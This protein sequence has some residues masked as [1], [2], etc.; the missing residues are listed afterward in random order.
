MHTYLLSW[1]CYGLESCVNISD[2]E[3]N[4]VWKTLKGESTARD[5]SLNQIVSMITLRARFNS[6]RHYEIYLIDTDD[7]ITENDLRNMF[8]QDPQGS[9]DLIRHRGRMLYSDRNEDHKIVIR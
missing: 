7:S 4:A 1:D 5:P 9:S 6:Q 2:I 8:E 3:K